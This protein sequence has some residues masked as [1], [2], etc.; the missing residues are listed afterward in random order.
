MD[1]CSS[2]PVTATAKWVPF[3]P[4]PSLKLLLILLVPPQPAPPPA[5]PAASPSLPG[6]CPFTNPGLLHLPCILKAG[7][8]GQPK[9]A[10]WASASAGAGFNPVPRLLGRT[11][12]ESAPLF[13]FSTDFHF[14]YLSHLPTRDKQVGV[15]WAAP[16]C[17]NPGG[18]PHILNLE[19]DV[20]PLRRREKR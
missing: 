9:A 6:E 14:G 19:L 10:P 12:R 5:P 13:P 11:R 15:S 3:G 8:M 2:S 4:S 16:L 7:E 20:M 1:N 18:L 17:Q